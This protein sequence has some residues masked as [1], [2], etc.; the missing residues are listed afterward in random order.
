[1]PD[2]ADLT[3]GHAGVPGVGV[4]PHPRESLRAV[5]DRILATLD[6]AER[7]VVV[8]A[9]DGLS[10]RAARAAWPAAD[11]ARLTSTF[12]STSA[13][14]WMTSV[15][16]L[17]VAGHLAIGAACRSPADGS[18]VNVIT[19]ETLAR[20]VPDRA[21]GAP[22]GGGPPEDSLSGGAFSGGGPPEDSLSGG[23]F[24]DGA[25]PGGDLI[26]ARTTVFERAAALPGT[27]AVAVGREIDTLTSPWSAALLRGAARF[28][29]FRATGGVPAA[30]RRELTAQALDPESLVAAVARDAEAAF[31]E[32]AADGR[33][34]L[35]WIYVN[36][37]DHFHRH[38]YDPR[39]MRAVAGLER[40][41]LS[42]AAR[43]WHVIA[44]SDHGQ[45]PVVPDPALEAAWAEVDAPELCAL[46]GGGAGRVR[47]LH[48][49]PGRA[50]E[51][52]ERLAAALGEHALVLAAGELPGLGLLEL[53]PAV[54]ERL[55]EVVA[56]A[57]SPRFPLPV[58]GPRFEHGALTED[59]MLV[60]LA[61]WPPA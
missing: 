26:A 20:A 29:A 57:A 11:L 52:A 2:D 51:A 22:P 27:V 46:P 4:T 17:P 18:L 53:T 37:D 59:E 34:L 44:H 54:R 10:W 45:V 60:P 47:W 16:G 19:G 7:G 14:A 49:R 8:L 55:G 1:M 3:G 31:A 13:T 32:H 40:H 15:T 39:A 12:P 9:V 25:P 50:G 48:P 38:G 58:R 23:A 41:A 35:L 43:G 24:S 36:L 61:L 30:R 21:D 33:R 5:P 28:P 6:R 56:V 42:W